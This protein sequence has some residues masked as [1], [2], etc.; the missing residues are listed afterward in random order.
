MLRVQS[1][2]NDTLGTE[3]HLYENNLNLLK[4]WSKRE[5][6]VEKR[7]KK[8]SDLQLAVTQTLQALREGKEAVDYEL[9]SL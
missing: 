2:K 3:L 9:V 5:R 6:K 7:K 1:L 4:K 8:Q